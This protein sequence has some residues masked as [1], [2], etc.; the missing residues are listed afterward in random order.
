MLTWGAF[1]IVGGEK[2]S[3]TQL[4]KE[5]K[6]L[7]KQMKQEIENLGIESDNSGWYGKV[8]LYCVES[9][10]PQTGWMVPL[11]PSLIISK[12]YRVI[13]ELVPDPVNKRY[14]IVLQ[15]QAT[16]KELKNS[17]QGTVRSEGR[18]QGPYMILYKFQS[19]Q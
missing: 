17:A 16:D 19:S 9:Q 5:Q 14:A 15:Y 12:G 13:A 1:H 6:F 11:L 8:Y 10:C 7:A 18:G 2:D 4:A 3:R